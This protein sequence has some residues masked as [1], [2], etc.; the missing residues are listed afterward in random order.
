MTN[1]C[2]QVKAAANKT[3][4]IFIYGDI[5]SKK[6]DESDVTA[7]A[8]KN[9]LD[10]LGDVSTL[11]VYINSAGGSVFEGLAIYNLLK[12]HPAHVNVH[13]DGLAA[14][15]ASIIVM[16]ADTVYMPSNAIFMI[17]EP[18]VMT[19][20]NAQALERMIA[21]L[22][23]TTEAMMNA[24]LERTGDKLEREQLAAMLAKES[25]L[26]AAECVQYGFADVITEELPYIAASISNE[27]KAHIKHIP[28]ELTEPK[29]ND[30]AERLALAAELKN[31]SKT[32][33]YDNMKKGIY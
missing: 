27:V 31:L 25:W 5:V 26:T 21:T 18:W 8:I 17:H 24:Y 20:G 12:R 19:S 30:Q 13:I 10:A 22:K 28:A 29:S 11:N 4:D 2:Y 3:A 1:K 14:S 32:N 7:T 16:A 9:E 6:W 33:Y 23:Q 15:I